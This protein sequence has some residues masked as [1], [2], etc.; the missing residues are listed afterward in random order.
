MWTIFPGGEMIRLSSIFYMLSM[1]VLTLWSFLREPVVIISEYKM[2]HLSNTRPEIVEQI[3]Y[4]AATV[5]L[6]YPP[7]ILRIP[8]SQTPYVFTFGTWKYQYIAISDKALEIW[9]DK[10]M[11]ESVM[12]HELGHL[13]SGDIWKTGW[14]FQ[15]VKWFGIL[16]LFLLSSS[17]FSTVTVFSISDVLRSLGLAITA[18]T[19]SLAVRF[20]FRIRE[21]V[22]DEFTLSFSVDKSLIDAFL[23][24]AKDSRSDNN[25]SAF[26]NVYYNN[27]LAN[28]LGFH[29]DTRSRLMVLQGRG[30]EIF[31]QVIPGLLFVAGFLIGQFT[32][33][34][35]DISQVYKVI[36]G[37]VLFFA[38]FFLSLSLASSNIDNSADKAFLLAE[39]TIKLITGVALLFIIQVL[40]SNFFETSPINGET[41]LIHSPIG[42]HHYMSLFWD[43]FLILTL[44][45]PLILFIVVW[46]SDIVTRLIFESLGIN[47]PIIIPWL[48]QAPLFI[49]LTWEWKNWTAGNSFA[50]KDIFFFM[51]I[52]A[53]WLI[54]FYVF[55]RKQSLKK[56]IP[57][58]HKDLL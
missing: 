33:F 48:M 50:I 51:P 45:L 44:I 19:I 9:A 23:A 39:S 31:N 6:R 34:Y 32:S 12:L 13:A 36:I 21:L 16:G 43:T 2:E 8:N 17:V 15:Y 46:V 5:N 1:V 57:A 18:L 14:S 56:T 7:I 4:L 42:L 29:P 37:G 10:K 38:S 47:R 41:L 55:F 11:L 24:T 28:F 25:H 49:F 40:P 53:F 27:W 26:E 52:W 22:A 30:E 35:S 58:L 20:L 3:L 54:V